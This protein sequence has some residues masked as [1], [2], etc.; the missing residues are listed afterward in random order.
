MDEERRA[1]ARHRTLKGARIVFNDGFS[2]FDC[3]VRNMSEAGAK[4]V[5]AGIVGIPQRFDLA[6]DDG[7]R[8]AC[9]MAWHR[10]GE[11]GVRFVGGV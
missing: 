11:I 9:E 5:V 1:S 4:L 2:T 3:K 6:M 8:F 7:R 10:D